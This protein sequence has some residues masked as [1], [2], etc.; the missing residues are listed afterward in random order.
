[1]VSK[2]KVYLETSFISYMVGKDTTNV[3]IASEKSGF[4]CP[5]ILKPSTC[6]EYMEMEG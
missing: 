4:V 2:P 5:Q 1:M 3:K 6:F